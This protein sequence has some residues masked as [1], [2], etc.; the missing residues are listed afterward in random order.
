LSWL[1]VVVLGI[2]WAAF[3]IP[4]RK[5]SAE[6]S[7]EEFEQQMNLLA[8]ANTKSPG[9]WVLMPRKERGLMSPK[10]RKRARVRR[11]R[12]QVFMVL[13]EAM[14]FALLMGLFPPLR[15]M[16]YGAAALA[17][18]LLCYALLLAKIREDE[19]AEARLRRQI[20]HRGEYIE[21]RNGN[22][23][24]HHRPA[25]QELVTDH[26]LGEAGVQLLEEDVHVVVRRSDEIDVSILQ[27]AAR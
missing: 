15:L 27:Q 6:S 13:L 2:I 12:R 17:L 26:F 4:S 1:L 14:S 5:R 19:L 8:E 9:R 22:G 11:R 25:N 16:L 24:G 3:L 7:I 21:A 23:N 18:V 10:D 20:G